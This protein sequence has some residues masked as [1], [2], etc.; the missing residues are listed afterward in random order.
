MSNRSSQMQY[1]KFFLIG[2]GV[3]LIIAAVVSPFA[4]SNPDGLE[5]VAEDLGFIDR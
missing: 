5:R 3:A 2:L 1:G 4:S